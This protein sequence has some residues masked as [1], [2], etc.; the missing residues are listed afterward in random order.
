MKATNHEPT[1][2]GPCEGCGRI[3]DVAENRIRG[4]HYRCSACKLVALAKFMET[5][6]PGDSLA[7]ISAGE[8]TGAW[9]REMALT[10]RRKKQL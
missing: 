6:D 3:V 7:D 10:G 9:L 1:P 8:Q 4:P 2:R 5:P